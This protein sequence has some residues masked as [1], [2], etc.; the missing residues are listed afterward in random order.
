VLVAQSNKRIIGFIHYIVHED[1]IDGGP[2]AFISAN[3]VA[4]GHRGRGVGTLLLKEMIKDTLARG[5][6]GVETSTIHA[7]AKK[8]YEMQHFKQTLGDIPEVFLE[9]DMQEYLR[10]KKARAR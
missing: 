2:N 5:A 1:I 10:A 8:F 3:Y 9:L 4:Y 6:V 7:R